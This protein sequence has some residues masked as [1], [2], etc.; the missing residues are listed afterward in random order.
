MKLP[1][2]LNKHID[3]REKALVKKDFLEMWQNMAVRTMLVIVPLIFVVLLPIFFM[4]LANSLPKS[5]LTGMQQMRGLLSDK[6]SYMNNRQLLFYVYS[7]CLGP[8]LYLIVP[9]MTACVTAASSFVGEKERGTMATLFLSPITARQIFNAKLIG[10]VGISALCSLISFVA[11]A[12]VMTIGDVLL[13][14]TAFLTNPSWIVM[15]LLLSPALIIFGALFMVLV[16]GRSHSFMESVQICGYVLL[17]LILLFV[18]Q[19]TGS[20]RLHAVHYLVLSL[21]VMVA[22]FIIW[23]I[24]SAHFTPEKLLQ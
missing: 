24:T 4:V 21:L 8:M 13:G 17:P 15:V 11:Y 10:S 22:D 6:Q 7:D 3:R 14:V 12:I 18:G 9:L 1:K 19:F 20:F 16:S 2:F 23:R 5:S